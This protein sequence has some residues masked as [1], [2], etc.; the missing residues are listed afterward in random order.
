MPSYA[1]QVTYYKDGK[2]QLSE[3]TRYPS[4]SEEKARS[5]YNNLAGVKSVHADEAVQIQL[6]DTT[7]TMCQLDSVIRL[8]S[9]ASVD[10]LQSHSDNYVEL[11][12]HDLS[13]L[14]DS[15]SRTRGELTRS[16]NISY[17]GSNKKAVIH[18][19]ELLNEVNAVRVKILKAIK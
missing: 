16:L 18:Y 3:V 1:I 4:I 14:A 6:F 10:W 7:D 15:L 9:R 11:S 13:V 12:Q 2:R 5:F 8:G 17:E 19:H